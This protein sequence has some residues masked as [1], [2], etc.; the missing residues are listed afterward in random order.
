MGVFVSD[1]VSD[2]ARSSPYRPFPGT[3]SMKGI[4][5]YTKYAMFIKQSPTRF[6]IVPKNDTK[7]RHG[8]MIYICGHLTQRCLLRHFN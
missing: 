5:I 1:F 4:I 7:T 3:C 2:Y 8:C 6:T